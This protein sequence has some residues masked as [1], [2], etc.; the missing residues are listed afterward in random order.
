MNLEDYKD[1]LSQVK[2]LADMNISKDLL[3]A[4]VVS[5]LQRIHHNNEYAV[6]I[7]LHKLKE[8]VDMVENK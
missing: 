8:F 5:L 1:T 6:I 4:I 7:H 2:M 3:E